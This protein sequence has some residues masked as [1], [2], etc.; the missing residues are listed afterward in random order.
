MVNNSTTE[1]QPIDVNNLTIVTMMDEEVSEV[2]ELG[3]VTVIL[4]GTISKPSTT[5]GL[6]IHSA[7]VIDY[8]EYESNMMF[9]FGEYLEQAYRIPPEE[10][11]IAVRA[12]DGYWADIWNTTLADEEKFAGKRG[13]IRYFKVPRPVTEICRE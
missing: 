1:M 4:N 9:L 3:D 5:K 6:C 7:E 10:K 13:D 2:F 11:F 12:E 8:T